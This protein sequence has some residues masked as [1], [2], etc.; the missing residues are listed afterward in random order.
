MCEVKGNGYR[1]IESDKV[2]G[3]GEVMCKAK[4]KG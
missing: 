4:V 3:L 2:K 1:L